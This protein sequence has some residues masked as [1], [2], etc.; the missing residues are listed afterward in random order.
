MA[1]YLRE[2]EESM[3]AEKFARLWQEH[4]RILILACIA[5]VIGTAAQAAWKSY[6]TNQSEKVTALFLDAVKST[7]STAALEKISQKNNSAN[8]ALASIYIG[9]LAVQKSDWAKALSAYNDVISNR[10]AHATYRD[11][12]IVQSVA[13]QIDHDPKATPDDLLKTLA[14]LLDPK[15]SIWSS[16]A[17]LLTAIIQGD[18]EKKYAE[19]T[20]TLKPLLADTS[21]PNGFMAQISAL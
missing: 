2:V 1:D 7:D 10:K 16:R 4:G 13:V 9:N 6:S 15:K 18:K 3:R 12:A 19:A 14:P 17:I 20:A 21:L 11:L 8:G 5:L